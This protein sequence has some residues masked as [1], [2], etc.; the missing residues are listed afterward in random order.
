MR[1]RVE[2]NVDLLVEL[3]PF[4]EEVIYTIL[5]TFEVGFGITVATTNHLGEVN[6]NYFSLFS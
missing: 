3:K 5:I 1:D 6:H 4:K 2:V